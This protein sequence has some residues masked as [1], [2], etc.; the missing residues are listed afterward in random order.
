[1]SNLSSW[2]TN[3]TFLLSLDGVGVLPLKAC[4]LWGLVGLSNIVFELRISGWCRDKVS[5]EVT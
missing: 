5:A 3:E 1:M 4:S 2:R